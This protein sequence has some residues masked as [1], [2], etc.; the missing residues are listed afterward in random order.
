MRELGLL[1]EEMGGLEG[2][3]EDKEDEKADDDNEKGGEYCIRI[4]VH[5][6][7]MRRRTLRWARGVRSL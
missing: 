1:T 3:G 4:W 5:G 7:I 6:L 2:M